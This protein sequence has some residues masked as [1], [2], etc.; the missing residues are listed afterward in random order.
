V[1]ASLSV[2]VTIPPELPT[3]A[4]EA[5]PRSITKGQSAV[6]SWKTKHA[7]KVQIQPDIGEVSPPDSGTKTVRPQET[8]TYVLIAT[9]PGGTSSAETRV[10]V[11]SAAPPS[12]RIVKFTVEPTQ[13]KRGQAVTVTWE[14]AN[15]TA[16][17]ITPGP[18]P[19]GSKGTAPYV[20][21]LDTTAFRLF[22][23]G[24]GKDNTASAQRGIFFLEPP[25]IDFS[26][27]PSQISIGQSARLD[28]SVKNATHIR[29]DPGYDNL[30][31]QGEENVH[32]EMNTDYSLTAEGLGGMAA[33]SV[34]VRVAPK[35]ISFDMVKVAQNRCRVKVLRWTVRG[36]SSLSIEPNV[37]SVDGRPYA[38][39]SPAQTTVY[40]L[41]AVGPG[42][43]D[44]RSATVVVLP[45]ENTG[46]RQP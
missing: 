1:D 35:I 7:A 6:L 10:E 22:A 32:P 14:V 13:V 17:N 19:A 2:T 21:P 31:S 42:G 16:V 11:A 4:L 3:A 39:V 38:I 18:G 37:G 40:T 34:S 12:V 26:G 43:S 44:K 23:T 45:G 5:E 25:T 8:A 28:W 33:K 41:T 24:E 46:C 15:A 9:G 27:T 36:A 29:I 30:R 20:P